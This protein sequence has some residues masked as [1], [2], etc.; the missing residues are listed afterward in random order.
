M[1]QSSA[2]AGPGA[3]KG[4]AIALGFMLAAAAVSSASADAEADKAAIAERLQRWAEAFNARD[5]S[6]TCDLFAPNLIASVRGQPDRGRDAICAQ[7]AAALADRGRRFSYTPE[8][9][10]IIVSGD[11]AVVRLVWT[12]TVGNPG[13]AHASQ[14]SGVDIF[15]RQPNG[16]WAII[17][18]LAF[19][20]DPD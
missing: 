5:A 11:L 18:Y 1:G 17:R 4:R 15:R 3:L 16:T 6:R 2:S 7:I 12:L 19:S 10:E 8:I 14:E 13:E 20:S 9:R